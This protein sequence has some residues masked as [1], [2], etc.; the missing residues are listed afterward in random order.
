MLIR[1]LEPDHG[2]A[3]MHERRGVID[4]RL[5]CAGPGRLCQALAIDKRLDGASL[6]AAP[7]EFRAPEDQP[8]I[9]VGARI[10]ISVG[11]QTPWRFILAGSLF[12]SRGPKLR[13]TTS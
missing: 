6:L 11:T 3:T 7:F 13:T 8:M 2:I 4:L 12:Q 5:L 10:G 9:E 1:A